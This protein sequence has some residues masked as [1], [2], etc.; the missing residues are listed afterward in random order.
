MQAQ[1]EIPELNAPQA[2][3]ASHVRGP[4]LVFAGAGSGKTRVIT[5]RIANLVACERVAPY[6]ILAVTF[7]NK[8]AGE[9]R[10]RLNKMLGEDVGRDL[11]VGTFH[12]TCAKLLRRFGEAVGLSKSFVIY[13]S[14]DQKALVTRVL[15]ELDYDERRYPPR[16]VLGRIHKEKQE[17]RGPE[18]MSLDSYMDDAIVKIFKRYEQ[19]LKSAGAVDFEDLIGYMVRLLENDELRVGDQPCHHLALIQRRDPIV[20]AAEHQRRHADASQAVANVVA[21]QFIVKHFGP[22]AGYAQQYLFHHVRLTCGKNLPVAGL[23]S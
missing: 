16:M 10:A 11:W 19:H 5:Y 1:A 3:A 13:D 7:T 18:D 15:R 4:L 22:N 14:S 23:K 12:A 8:A 9:M 20:P 6:R 17:A 21:R 2:E